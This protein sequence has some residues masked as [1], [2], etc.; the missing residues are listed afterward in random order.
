MAQMGFLQ[1]DPIRAPARAQDL[2]LRQR[3][4]GYRA[5]DLERR[6]KT[7]DIEEDFFINYGFVT[8]EV[9]RLMHPR[10]QSVLRSGRARQLLEFVG[11]RDVVHP[12]E[13][14]EYFAHGPVTNYW[15][16]TSNATTHLLDKMHYQ[17][18]LRIAGRDNGIRTYSVHEHESGSGRVNERLDR[19]VDIVVSLYAPLPATSFAYVIRRLRYAAPQWAG[20]ITAAQ[21]RAKRRFQ[22]ARIDGVDWYWPAGE[23]TEGR[24]AP[25]RVRLLA[26]FD[27]VVW[28]RLRFELLWGWAYR[29]E[30]YTPA[31]KR[32]L[33]YYALPVLWKDSVVGWANL[34]VEGERLAADVGFVDAHPGAS[35]TASLEEELARMRTFLGL[36]E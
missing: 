21:Q 29:F 25:A 8:R 32:K 2:V 1:A 31:P 7:L 18:L 9:S 13:A 20:R 16:G 3:V 28:D 14:D 15:G 5:G 12:R 35:F 17:G 36:R 26:P 22:H 6:Y 10:P 19:L 33:G 30:A 27:P 4:R 23:S 24:D 11:E 34:R